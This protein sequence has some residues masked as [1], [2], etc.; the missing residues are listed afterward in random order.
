VKIS[1][2]ITGLRAI[3]DDP[4][5]AGAQQKNTDATLTLVG[6]EQALALVK[7][8][9]EVDQRWHNAEFSIL[10]TDARQ[11]ASDIWEYQLPP[12]V[13]TIAEMREQNQGGS[14]TVSKGRLVLP[15]QSRYQYGQGYEL[16]SF[17]SFRFYGSST[18]PNLTLQ[19]AKRPARPT[20]GSLP[21][22]SS[23]T[24]S[25]LRLDADNSSDA[26]TYPHETAD[27]SYAGSI[28]EITGVSS[29]SHAVGGQIRRVLS[30]AHL[31]YVGAN[32][33]TV[34]TL[35]KAWTV[36]P[37]VTA[38]DTYEMHWEIPDT[39]VRLHQL[40]TARA[41]WQRAGNKDEVAAH[42]DETQE[43][44]MSLV[45]DIR[46]RQIQAPAR[47]VTYIGGTMPREDPDGT[48]NFYPYG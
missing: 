21:D 34:L 1:D 16:Q 35:D 13:V 9:A 29:S 5:T 6:H 4:V 10:G 2:W 45:N 12:W 22:Q 18:A 31:Q 24:T 39:H 19:V 26:T 36:A 23:I 20:K 40:L 42:R 17:N 28:V 11:I 38:P 7:R 44:W 30:S 37:N 32:P 8:M 33:F 43:T 27:N 46:N 3:L 41:M 48:S 47:M 14:A 15:I 25:Q